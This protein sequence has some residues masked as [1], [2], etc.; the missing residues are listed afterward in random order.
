MTKISIFR[1]LISFFVLI[2]ASPVL[3]KTYVSLTPVATE[4]IYS[5]G[6]DDKLLGVS[7]ACDYPVGVKNKQIIG[8]T[9]FVNMDYIVR[10]KP[11]YMFAMQSAKP[12]LGELSLTKTEPIYFEFSKIDDIYSAI[13]KIANLIDKNKE[14]KILVN[15]I[16]S[17]IAKYKTNKPKNILYVVQTVPL[18]TIGKESFITDVIRQSGHKSLTSDIAHYYPTISLE[19]VLKT[20]PDVI[21]ICFGRETD[22]MRKLFPNSEFIYLTK[23]QSDLI[24]RPAPRVWQAVKFFAEI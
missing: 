16:K 18:I 2:F 20:P 1:F 10:T 17:K 19:Y 5:L 11:D 12:M 21:I 4:I 9:Y 7:S 14:A 8:D 6:A 23:E 24:N 22:E 13:F 3:A 15:Q